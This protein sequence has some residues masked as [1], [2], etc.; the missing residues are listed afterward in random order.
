[1]RAFG[2]ELALAGGNRHVDRRRR[3]VGTGITVQHPRPARVNLSGH[4]GLIRRSF[5]CPPP[6]CRRYSLF[7]LGGVQCRS[8]FRFPSLLSFLLLYLRPALFSTS[9]F[10]TLLS[11]VDLARGGRRRRRPCLPYRADDVDEGC[12]R[13]QAALE[14]RIRIHFPVTF[15]SEEDTARRRRPETGDAAAGPL[16]MHRRAFDTLALLRLP[17]VASV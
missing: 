1:M 17:P 8:P 10:R 12:V 14:P 9:P 11:D 7:L 15:V 5:L 16:S 6:P 4:D 2:S 3:A 13:C